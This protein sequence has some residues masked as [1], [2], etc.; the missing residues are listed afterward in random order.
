MS[1][2]QKGA[3]RPF[4]EKKF[5]FSLENFERKPQPSWTSAFLQCFM[6]PLGPPASQPTPPPRIPPQGEIQPP[7]GP[8]PQD[9]CF[10]VLP[11]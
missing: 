6:C 5:G 10:W 11:K 4:F 7:T 3:N 9:P 2:F 1:K 8:R